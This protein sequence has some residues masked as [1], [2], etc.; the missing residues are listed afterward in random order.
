MFNQLFTQPVSTPQPA[1]PSRDIILSLTA[2]GYSFVL[3]EEVLFQMHNVQATLNS[4]AI[5]G[6]DT[7]AFLLTWHARVR[8]H[9]EGRPLSVPMFATLRPFQEPIITPAPSAL[10]EIRIMQRAA[11]LSGI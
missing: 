8:L 5:E 7:P 11:K 3:P 10:R 4:M 6:L 1:P 2:L 9:P